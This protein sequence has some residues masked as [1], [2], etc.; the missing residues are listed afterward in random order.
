VVIVVVVVVGVSVAA[1]TSAELYGQG[2]SGR[3]TETVLV[4][5]G[6]R[7]VTICGVDRPDLV[8]ENRIKV[9][10]GWTDGPGP[11]G[12]VTFQHLAPRTWTSA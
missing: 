4:K 7:S 9:R 11:V 1:L 12:C 3:G 6:V 8:F 10:G 2:P 5:H